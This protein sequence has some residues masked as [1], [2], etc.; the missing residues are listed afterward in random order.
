MVGR[1][2]YGERPSVTYG[3][4]NVADAD[5]RSRFPSNSRPMAS[6]PISASR[7]IKLYGPSGEV[8]WGLHHCGAWHCVAMHTDAGG[9]RALR[10][11]SDLIRNP[12]AWSS[13]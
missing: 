1:L 10:M 8:A 5:W 3:A 9:R 7:P 11:T 6:A 12:I 2:K 4:G 13:S